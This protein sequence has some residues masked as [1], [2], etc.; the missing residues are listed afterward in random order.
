VN[1]KACIFDLDGTL[2]NTLPDIRYYLNTVLRKYS[3]P[4]IDEEKTARFV[5]EGALKLVCR[6][7]ADSGIDITSDA[8][9]E[10]CER[11]CPEY[12]ALYDA[13]PN[14]LTAPYEGIIE[15]L[16]KLHSAGIRLAVLSN[17]PD[18]TVKQLAHLY[19]G[20]IFD[21]VRGALPKVPLKPDPSSA[22]DICREL[23]VPPSEVAYFG[24]TATDIET[25]LS[26]GAK[27][28][29]GVLWGFRSRSELVGAGADAVIA[30]TDKICSEILGEQ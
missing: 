13:N 26:L 21:T 24:D 6:A 11:I 23:S 20:D 22:L 12:V 5:G 3:I 16:H 15:N 1:I 4:E 8:G 29:V 7:V 28:T 17:K 19:F 2:L 27:K 30:T 25:G 18:S 9:K 10:L 14:Y